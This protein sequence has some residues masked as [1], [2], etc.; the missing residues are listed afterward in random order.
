MSTNNGRINKRIP[1]LRSVAITV[2]KSQARLY[3]TKDISLSGMFILGKFIHN[4]RGVCTIA[5]QESWADRQFILNL[6]G[7]VTRLDWDGI[8]IR[9]TEMDQETYSLLQTLLLYECNNPTTMGEEFVQDCSYA[10]WDSRID[11]KHLQIAESMFNT[12]RLPQ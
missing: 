6:V 10:V 12:E 7:K 9:Y 4:P 2:N 11:E 3:A 5:L 8:A 1:L